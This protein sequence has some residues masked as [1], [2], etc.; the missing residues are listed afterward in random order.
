MTFRP[1]IS[2]FSYKKLES[3][4]GSKQKKI[5]LK[6]SS[7][8]SKSIGKP[9]KPPKFKTV[10]LTTIAGQEYLAVPTHTPEATEKGLNEIIS[11]QDFI[12]QCYQAELVTSIVE[13]AVMKSGRIKGV[14]EETVA[15]SVVAAKLAAFGQKQVLSK[16]NIYN[17]DNYQEFIDLCAKSVKGLP[18]SILQALSFQRPMFGKKCAPDMPYGWLSEKET[19]VLYQQLSKI[20]TRLLSE[21]PF[22]IEFFDFLSLVAK[23]KMA[24]WLMLM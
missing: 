11:H 18:T 5:V 19:A 21:E 15:H 6:L 12:Y 7:E 8:I 9:P 24:L 4:L 10:K 14:N 3:I 2:G 22:T 1:E 20:Q 16:L 13:H 17:E 23:K